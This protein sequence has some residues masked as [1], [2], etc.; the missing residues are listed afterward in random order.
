MDWFINKIS[1]KLLAYIAICMC[2]W[3]WFVIN[4]KCCKNLQHIVGDFKLGIITWIAFTIFFAFPV[5][6]V[7]AQLNI[8]YDKKLQCEITAV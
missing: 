3:I 4:S 2:G 6:F 1:A 8:L 5:L 7:K